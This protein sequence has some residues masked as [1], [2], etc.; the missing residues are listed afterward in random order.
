MC[1]WLINTN[2]LNIDICLYEPYDMRLKLMYMF[3]S[4]GVFKKNWTHRIKWNEYNS[5]YESYDNLI[6]KVS[7]VL[8][9][10]Y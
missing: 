10:G 8:L 7:V 4:N 1:F 2:Q 3:I 6:L 5:K 9:I